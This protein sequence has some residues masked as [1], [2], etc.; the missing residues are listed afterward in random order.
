LLSFSGSFLVT[1]KRDVLAFQTK[2]GYYDE[3]MEAP[4][5]NQLMEADLYLLLRFSLDDNTETVVAATLLALRNLLL[6]H[7]DEVQY[8]IMK[9]LERK[10][11]AS[12]NIKL[13]VLVFP[14][15]IISFSV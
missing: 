11:H 12:R 3:C 10:A 15:P 7:P 5:L 9:A 2:A 14:K 8:R 4:L 6:N 13:S 1:E